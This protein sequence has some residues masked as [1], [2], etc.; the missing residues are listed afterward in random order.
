MKNPI[1]RILGG[2]LLVAVA[3]S[4]AFAGGPNHMYDATS[5]TPYVWKMERWQGGAVPVYTD[6]G[7][8]KN[9]N[10]LISNAAANN[11]TVQAW[12]QWNN[13][14]TSTFRARVVGDVSLLGLGDVTAANAAQVFPAWNGGGITVVYD[15]TGQIFTNYL[16]LPG[17]VLGIS[18]HEFVAADSNEILENTVFLNG[19]QIRTNDPTGARFAGVFTHEFGHSLN[20]RHTQGNGAIWHQGVR[21][22]GFPF[23]CTNAPYAGGPGVGPAA[24]QVETM[25]PFLDI[26]VGGSGEHQFSVDLMDDVSAISDLYPAP[27][28]P[29]SH[30]TIKG[31]IRYLTKI[32]GNGTGPTEEITGVNII[33]RNLA[34]PYGDFTTTTS[35]ELTRGEVGADGSYELH[36]LTPGATYGIYVDRFLAG[37]FPT[38]FLVTLPGAEEWY[39]AANESGNG[40]TDNRCAWTGVQVSAGAAATADITFNRVKGAPTYTRFDFAGEPSAMTPDGSMMV[41]NSSNLPGYWTWSEAEGY[42]EIGGFAAIGGNPWISDDGS[43]VA[44]TLDVGGNVVKWALWDHATR[45]WTALP[46]PTPGSY[47]TTSTVF[48]TKLTEG[49]VFGMSGDGSTIV[50]LT[51]NNGPNSCRRPLGTKWTAAGGSVLLEKYPDPITANN[52]Q[53]RGNKASY[54]GSIIVG[55]DN[56]PGRNGVYWE[57]GVEH[58]LGSP[59]QNPFVNEALFVTRDGTIILGGQANNV[60]GVLDG[61][62][63]YNRITGEREI[64]GPATNT[65]TPFAFRAN[66]AA[67]VIGGFVNDFNLGGVVPTIW[68]PQLGWTN[69][70]QFLESQGLYAQGVLWA[71]IKSISADGT[72]WATYQVTPGGFRPTLVHIPKAIV[73]HKS[74]GNPH[75]KEKNLDVAFP[76]GLADHLAH[77]DTVGLC[78]NGGE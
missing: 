59:T 19:A 78:Q 5:K 7:N 30:G 41:G 14:P 27:G 29:E 77:G 20:L 66:D 24:N 28:W 56:S 40:E 60:G 11:W 21:D 3:A 61:A 4:P 73:C 17:S 39:N 8:L 2:A 15:A 12:D 62:W 58:F 1:V 22:T 53:N 16:G 68:T 65:T 26:N 47:C 36:G 54:D 72:I 55:Y 63:K 13:V 32:R 31:T 71:N 67:D 43:K 50:G 51:Y 37:A 48:G 52:P 10:P 70:T 57:N 69:L 49:S 23:G 42:Q 64:I 74:P 34:N 9:A 45:T 38:P 76:G 46:N 44:G 33:A 75:G 18:L 35:G 25:Y 6:L